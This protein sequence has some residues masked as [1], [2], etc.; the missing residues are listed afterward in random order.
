M[1]S[2][3]SRVWPP[4][5]MIASTPATIAGTG[6]AADRLEPGLGEERRPKAE[7][8]GVMIIDDRDRDHDAYGLR[9]PVS[10]SGSRWWRSLGLGS[11]GSATQAF[12]ASMRPRRI[13]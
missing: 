10:I 3:R 4:L 6:G 1:A 9:M 2:N 12:Q 8:D 7:S 11:M 5:W 13:A